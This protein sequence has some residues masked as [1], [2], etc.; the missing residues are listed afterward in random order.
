M[1]ISSS[2]DKNAILKKRGRCHIKTLIIGDIHLSRK[3]IK[4]S[5]LLLS[6]ISSVIQEKQPEMVVLLGDVFDTHDV[7]SNDCLSIFADFVRKNEQKTV[8]HHVVG[9]HE[10]NDSRTFLPDVH[11]LNPW[12]G[13][14]NFFVHDRP[15][16]FSGPLPVAFVPFVPNGMFKKALQ[17]LPKKPKLVFAHQEFN[18][19]A[20]GPHKISEGGDEEPEFQVI[21]GHIHGRQTL[22][23]VWYPGTPCQHRFTE[24]LEKYIYMLN[25]SSD[26]YQVV[27]QIDL[28]LP[29]FYTMH[30]SATDFPDIPVNDENEY[31]IVVK[32]TPENILLFKKTEFY[33]E[34]HQNVKFKFDVIKQQAQRLENQKDLSFRERFEELVAE[35]GLEGTYEAIFK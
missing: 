25:L 28:E 18:G 17:L 32:D 16:E 24:E 33:M 9:N 23:N 29:K 8:L 26:G 6:K 21:S 27:E 31:R 20:M 19:C 4:R 12:K 3:R 30:C 1:L 5:Q 15:A 35:E 7:Q 11:A 22:G 14:E 2:D 34:K 10:M 13:R